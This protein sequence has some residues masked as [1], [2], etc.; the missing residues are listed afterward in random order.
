MKINPY[1]VQQT[2]Q[3]QVLISHKKCSYD[4]CIPCLLSKIALGVHYD[5]VYI[6]F[7]SNM[8]FPWFYSKIHFYRFSANVLLLTVIVFW[9][10]VYHTWICINEKIMILKKKKKIKLYFGQK[11]VFLKF[12]LF[13]PLWCVCKT[14][15]NLCLWYLRLKSCWDVKRRFGG[16]AHY[17]GVVMNNK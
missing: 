8:P 2:M 3:K 12:C 11:S 10:N 17:F 13:W 1:F 9:L 6:P 4:L 14:R 7:L 15:L 16:L 5:S